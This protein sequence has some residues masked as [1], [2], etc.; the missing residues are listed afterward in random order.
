MKT[1]CLLLLSVFILTGSVNAQSVKGNPKLRDVKKIYVDVLGDGDQAEIVR[2]KLKIRLAEK[3]QFQIVENYSEADA[4]LS[5]TLTLE[6]DI[7]SSGGGGTVVTGGKK[8]TTV[9]TNNGSN[10]NSMFI[11]VF[12]LRDAKTGDDLWIYDFSHRKLFG[13]FSQANRSSSDAY[14]QVA[15]RTVKKLL[16]AVEKS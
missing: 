3:G 13:I 7:T 15:K 10:T 11:G 4:V 6:K 9:I 5:G 1:F 2:E 16:E 8:T 14:N 12:R